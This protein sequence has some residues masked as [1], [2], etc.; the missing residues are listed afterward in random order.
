MVS[1]QAELRNGTLADPVDVVV[2]GAGLAG[3]VAARWL[4]QAA[5]SV[6]LIEAAEQP[7]GRM[8][9]AW[10]PLAGGAEG[11]GRRPWIDLGGQWV[12]PSQTR[13]LALLERHR[14]RRF[15]SPHS[16]DTVLVFGEQ[17][18]RF[19][20]FFQG[21]P[22]GQ[23]PAVPEADWA[24]AMAALEQFQALVAQLPEGHPHHHPAAASLD[25]LSFQDWI[26]ANTHT[27]FAAWYFAYFCRAVGFLG[28]AEPEQVSLLHV[29]WGQR[30]APQGEHPEEW[31]L[32]GGAG[33]LPA[34]LAAELGESRAAAG[35]AGARRGAGGASPRGGAHGPGPL[36]LPR[37][38]RGHAAGDGEPAP[39]HSGAARRPE[40]TPGRNGDGSLRQGA[41]GL[42]QPLVA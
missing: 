1:S 26:D 28:P 30:T 20:G 13:M 27:P 6:R 31:L 3:L 15:A 18:C 42:C 34:L 14:I 9:G 24:D 21:F 12:G 23:P 32:H 4:Q 8:R 39:V 16:G 38:D 17:R 25:R 2:V 40:A 36:P 19:S 5:C 10:L 41:G 35:R 22:E 37:R 11:P 33:Q 7:G 29:L